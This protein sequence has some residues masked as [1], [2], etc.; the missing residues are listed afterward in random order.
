MP[1]PVQLARSAEELLQRP[2]VK[3][4]MDQPAPRHRKNYFLNKLGLTHKEIS[5]LTGVTASNISRDLWGYK[6]GRL[7]IPVVK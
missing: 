5:T 3:Y 2:D 6:S 1:R 7:K 4:I